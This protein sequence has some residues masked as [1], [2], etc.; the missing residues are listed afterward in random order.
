MLLNTNCGV[1]RGRRRGAEPH[2]RQSPLQTHGKIQ[3]ALQTCLH[4]IGKEI[5]FTD[6]ALKSY[7]KGKEIYT[8]APYHESL[9][10]PMRNHQF[11]VPSMLS[12]VYEELNTGKS[13]Q[14]EHY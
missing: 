14:N 2:R 8:F 13:L 1:L 11:E 3:P 6:T 7:V 12:T 5:G 4:S 10:Q 9:L